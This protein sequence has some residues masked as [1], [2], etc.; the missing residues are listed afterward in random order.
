MF[1]VPMSVFALH[2]SFGLV[3][4]PRTHLWRMIS[5]PPR[6]MQRSAP[7]SKL[8]H[9]ANGVRPAG[10]RGQV[11]LRVRRKEGSFGRAEV[12]SDGGEEMDLG[13]SG[14]DFVT[15]CAPGVA[16]GG[17]SGECSCKVAYVHA[18]C[19]VGSG[20]ERWR[21]RGEAIRVSECGGPREI[22]SSRPSNDVLV[23]GAALKVT[24][25]CM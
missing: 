5:L 8:G 4:W 16:G 23:A 17:E 20:L 15:G 1:R 14:D 21:R 11:T 9:P 18:L 13:E 19:V 22:R 3:L 12:G 2:F 7:T 24:S 25:E 6:I 10:D